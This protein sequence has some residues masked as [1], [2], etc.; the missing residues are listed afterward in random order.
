MKTLFLSSAALRSVAVA[1]L[2]ATFPP[3]LTVSLQAQQPLHARSSESESTGGRSGLV[4]HGHWIIDVKDRNGNVVEHR[5]FQ[6]SLVPTGSTG[7][8]LALTGQLVYSSGFAIAVKDTNSSQLYQLYSATYPVAPCSAE[9]QTTTSGVVVHCVSGMTETFPS[10]IY[11][12]TPTCTAS[13]GIVLQG[14]FVASSPLAVN[15]VQTL[16]NVC[17]YSTLLDPNASAPQT[18]VAIDSQA[19]G[20]TTAAVPAGVVRT[21]LGFTA[22]NVNTLNVA[23]G[24]SLLV[25]VIISFS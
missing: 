25:K 5:D 4:V 7:F 12:Q 11:S 9:G 13:S 3:P 23:V 16:N 1:L 22:T 10:C 2:L 24:Q 19:C 15:A 8:A 18:A 20:S 17:T 6:N 14:S 21:A